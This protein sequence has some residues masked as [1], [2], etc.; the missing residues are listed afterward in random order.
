MEAGTKL[1]QAEATETGR[2]KWRVYF[3]YFGAI[4]AAWMAPILVMNLSSQALS[5]GS[6]LWLTA[7]SNDPPLLEE[8][9]HI[10][11][12]NLRLGVYG[13]LGLAQGVTILLGS[14]ALSLG[15]L[16]GAMLLHNGLLHN[17]LR[18]PMSFFDTTPV[19]RIVN[20][21]SKDVDTIDLTIPTTVR[22]CLMYFLQMI[23]VLFI[24]TLTTP[25]FLV[26]ALPVFFLYYFIQ[27][28]YV[29]TSRQLKRLDSVTRSPIY[30]HFSETLSGVSTI[31]AYGAQE[32]FV[33]ESHQL[34]DRNQMCYYP[35]IIS[36][37]WLA[38]RLEFCGNLIVLSAALFAVFGREH[39]DGG[40]VGLSLSYALSIT[41]T[42]NWM[43]RMS[44][45]F[46][47]N[48]VAVERIMEY[49]RSPT[50]A[51][52]K[53]PEAK[54]P[55]EW[56]QGG[57]VQFR[58]YSTRYRDGLELTIKDITVSVHPGEKVFF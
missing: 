58:D 23:S 25:I 36:N 14:L 46:E 26:V 19:G 1:V 45:E 49:S 31:R 11:K 41:A 6:N 37:R 44:C 38:V 34:I 12:R 56:P 2:V 43:V 5:I 18:S 4:G 3:A 39:L 42:I 27:A 16:K 55:E 54:L 13:A 21:F 51:A 52:W 28:F 50:E 24:I 48:I 33:Q 15:S 40:L 29:A 9:Q 17:I 35:S 30:T 57:E 53:V 20:R 32:R 47:T 7:W 8:S 10:A 22:Q